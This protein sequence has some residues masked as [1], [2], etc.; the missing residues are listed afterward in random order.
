MPFTEAEAA[1]VTELRATGLSLAKIGRQLGCS[2]SKVFTFLNPRPP[3]PKAEKPPPLTKPKYTSLLPSIHHP[4][5]SVP[6]TRPLTSTQRNRPQLTKP[7]M[8]RDLALA[9][10]NT[11]RLRA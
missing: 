3:K 1:L 11:A 2:E 6:I 7:E 4:P 5:G 9:V 10:R 8:E